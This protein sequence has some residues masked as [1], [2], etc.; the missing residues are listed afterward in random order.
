MVVFIDQLPSILS[1]AALRIGP[2]SPLNRRPGLQRIH[3]QF[4]RFVLK[5]KKKMH[6]HF[7]TAPSIP[8]SCPLTIGNHFFPLVMNRRPVRKSLTG[9]KPRESLRARMPDDGYFFEKQFGPPRSFLNSE[10][11]NAL[12]DKATTNNIRR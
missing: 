6:F 7:L 11:V 1:Q 3:C 4:V 8:V 10:S 5:I 2:T 12:S 9:A